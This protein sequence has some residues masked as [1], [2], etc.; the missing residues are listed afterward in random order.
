MSRK[1]YIYNRAA[2]LYKRG[3][4]LRNWMQKVR[5]HR[6]AFHFPRA[7]PKVM[8]PCSFPFVETSNF[9]FCRNL[10]FLSELH[11]LF[12]GNLTI[13]FGKG[14]TA[15]TCNLS[16]RWLLQLNQVKFEAFGKWYRIES[17][18]LF[19]LKIWKTEVWFKRFIKRLVSCQEEKR[20][21]QT[22]RFTRGQSRQTV[23]HERSESIRKKET[24]WTL[25]L[26]SGVSEWANLGLLHDIT[27]R[28]FSSRT[29]QSSSR[30]SWIAL[31]LF[32]LPMTDTK[33]EEIAV[34]V[35]LI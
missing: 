35:G 5:L 21:T 31:L 34:L 1:I 20:R 27:I 10:N 28:V 14:E 19:V 7:S 3:A 26:N 32:L 8:Q 4:F 16:P 17:H 15:Q 33:D 18:N 13:F 9:L 30:E 23:T 29:D 2:L 12:F 6:A 11:F 24:K 25:S 22:F